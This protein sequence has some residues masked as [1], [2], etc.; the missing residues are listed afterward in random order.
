MTG[1]TAVR[2]LQIPMLF[3]SAASRML[4][5]SP[6]VSRM[7]TEQSARPHLRKQKLHHLAISTLGDCMFL[8]HLIV[9][10][11]GDKVIMR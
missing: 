8:M 6:T 7:W 10:G 2:L 4:V 9:D 11:D 5:Q 3:W 1:M